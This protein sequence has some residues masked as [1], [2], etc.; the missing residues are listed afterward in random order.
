MTSRDELG[1]LSATFNSMVDDMCASARLAEE[2]AVELRAQQAILRDSEAKFR[3]MFTSSSDALILQDETG[4]LDC[5]QAAL[6][7]FGCSTV[8]EFRACALATFSPPRQPGGEDSLLM[9]QEKI[10]AAMT[11]GSYSFEWLHQRADGQSFPADVLLT[12]LDLA[13][14]PVLHA[15]VR[16]VT[17]RKAEEETTRRRGRLDAMHSEIGAALVQSQGFGD[18]MQQCAEALLRGVNAAFARIWMLEPETDT[19]VLCTS[20]G[21]YTHLDGSHSRVKVGERKVGRIAATRQPIETNSALT[22]PGIDSEWASAQGIV[23]LG[24]YPLVV[25]TRL[26]GVVVVFARGHFAGG[27]VLGARAGG[28]PYQSRSGAQANRA[29]TPFRKGKGRGSHRSQIYVPRQHEPRDS[30]TD[31]RGHRHDAPRFEDGPHG[32]TT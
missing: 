17:H 29:G 31:E 27:G 20:V 23:A 8:D 2:R 6:H 32:Q 13:G 21:L 12:R 5:N 14:K 25:H 28:G 26:V 11:A 19:L 9:A 16:D 7:M 22:E 24:G 4:F 10:A 30:H 15:T 18:M 1:M 3:T